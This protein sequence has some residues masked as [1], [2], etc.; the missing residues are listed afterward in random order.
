MSAI[1]TQDQF[2]TLEKLTARCNA[3]E[4]K[5]AREHKARL[6][7]EA[8]AET[9][10]RDLY[11]GS[12]RLKLL[13]RI[14]G[15]ANQST[16]PLETMQFAAREICK[17]TGWA[18]GT[19]LVVRKD[20]RSG[21]ACLYANGRYYASQPD[22]VF[23]FVNTPSDME[24]WPSAALPGRLL[25]HQKPF[26]TAS[27]LQHIDSR[28]LVA[29]QK[30]NLQ[31][32]TFVPVCINDELVAA[33]EFAQHDTNEPQA[34]MLE[35]LGQIGMQIGRVFKRERHAQMLIEN[36]ATDM[37][38][39]LA[40]RKYLH[41]LLDNKYTAARRESGQ[42]L[43][44]LYIDMDGFKMVNDSMGHHIGDALLV[45][46]AARLKKVA[47][48]YKPLPGVQSINI[49]RPGGDE[50][51]MVV[52]TNSIAPVFEEIAE[53]LHQC[54][55]EKCTIDEHR[56]HLQ[57]SIGIAILRDQH[58]DGDDV[59]RDADIAMY[60]AKA[61]STDKTAVFAEEMRAEALKNAELEHALRRAIERSEFE[62]HYQPIVTMEQGRAVGFEALIRWRREDGSLV[63]PDSFIPLAESSSLI[64]AIGGWVIGEACRTATSWRGQMP[65]D[66][67]FY[68]SVNV[69]TQQFQQPEFVDQ[70][71]QNLIDHDTDPANIRLELT[72]SSAIFNDAYAA[73][74]IE[75]L[76][77]IGICTSLDDFGTGYSS[78][79]Y[80]KS[81]RFHALKIDRSFITNTA[82]SDAD[83]SIVAA[84]AQLGKTLDME[85]VVEGIETES[86]RTQLKKMGLSLGQGWLF[87]KAMPQTDAFALLTTASAV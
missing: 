80:L 35:I 23:P 15:M 24:F 20:Q 10:L 68:I 81:M 59:L 61:S 26:W 58:D 57:A 42:Q 79:S 1:P 25:I 5:L 12:E 45:E 84:I 65:S 39:G 22:R 50:F 7:S 4:R 29:A 49:A 86:Q 51:V 55:R 34:Q 6:A 53:S 73:E 67:N 76:K 3:L 16:E 36:A 13:W 62:L 54:L 43:A 87:D 17:A 48:E 74:T 69:A 64:L 31:S 8:I 77:A 66:Q 14:T 28:R 33:L 18:L 41:E 21:Q 56:L 38:T 27:L 78:L 52:T 11:L 40:N 72:E 46:I 47:N 44:V 30:S 82:K 2:E 37:L 32:G 9:S 83:W 85:I 60:K 71:R 70:M 63:M 19:I 75:R